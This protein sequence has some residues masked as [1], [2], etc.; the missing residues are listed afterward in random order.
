MTDVPPTH[1]QVDERTL[2]ATQGELAAT[3]AELRDLTDAIGETRTDRQTRLS[4][5]GWLLTDGRD[6]GADR[7]CMWVMVLQR[8]RVRRMSTCGGS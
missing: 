2:Q 5:L 8:R 6:Q 7:P 4:L 1:S 3:R